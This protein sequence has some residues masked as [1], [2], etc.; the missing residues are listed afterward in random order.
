MPSPLRFALASARRA[1]G[2]LNFP[3]VALIIL[4]VFLSAA[5]SPAQRPPD[6]CSFT[7]SQAP[8]V[9]FEISVANGQSEFR[10]GEMIPLTAT[11]STGVQ[12][13]YA[14]EMAQTN[15]TGRDMGAEIVCVDPPATDP[16]SDHFLNSGMGGISG[17]TDLSAEPRSFPVTVNDWVSLRPGSYRVRVVGYRI[18]QPDPDNPQAPRNPLVMVSNEVSIDVAAA[19]KPWQARE[20]ASAE[21]ELDSA[22]PQSS[23]AIHAAQVM[24]FLET[25]DSTRELARRFEDLSWSGM[26]LRVGL[27]A[28]PYSNVAIQTMKAEMADPAHTITHAYIDTLIELELQSDPRFHVT[29]ILGETRDPRVI[30]AFQAKNTEMEKRRAVYLDQA[31]AALPSKMPVARAETA[32]DLL[33][34]GLR[35]DGDERT[36]AIEALISVWDSLP[37]DRRSS[38][39][40]GSW[41]AVA[42]PAWLP[43][44]RAIADSAPAPS[45]QPQPQ[46]R[47]T[48]IEYIYQLAPAEGR[49]RILR[50]IAQPHGD[51][52]IEVLGMLPD[53]QLPQFDRN[54]VD[55][56]KSDRL[57]YLEMQLVERY[58]SGAIFPDVRAFHEARG[59][60]G[61][62]DA[63]AALLRYFLR[64]NPDYG[65]AQVVSA[66]SAVGHGAM[67]F[68]LYSD[69]KED[70]AR[71]QIEP[72]VIA[73][74]SSPEPFVI[75]QAARA[76][77]EYGSPKAGAA[78]WARL[79]QLHQQ[80]DAPAQPVVIS[81]SESWP[82][83]DR[84]AEFSILSAL[85]SGHSWFASA[86]MI[87]KLKS[88]SDPYF[89]SY[90]EEEASSVE[91]GNFSLTL[92]WAHGAMQY[93][94]GSSDGYGITSLKEKLAQFPTGS[95]LFFAGAAAERTAH[96]DDIHAVEAAAQ[97]AGL[98]LHTQQQE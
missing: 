18:T 92:S 21:S 59:K 80:G 41:D 24:T 63:H 75:Q 22:G 66:A 7:A 6:P 74:L 25:E 19:G 8:E 94:V 13:K 31:L 95:A 50:E 48:A 29:P 17:S 23:E 78:L 5:S 68:W 26:Q 46:L 38:V 39:L 51:I 10:E 42:S 70:V 62:C 84:M 1:R 58:A 32:L 40:L 76:L 20:L 91:A 3:A 65:V 49:E 4:A 87:R 67:C 93:Q 52:G 88:I 73:R 55:G 30:A 47:Q 12:R 35:L 77:S 60:F 2:R 43:I 90:L 27:Y 96:A 61:G 54:F 15:S 71:P 14:I 72:L 53:R 57:A 81:T 37:A 69:L 44:L 89:E 16:L 98:T 9:S 64:V 82:R 11:Y 28:S 79:E 34:G 86:E 85:V 33:V 97:A 56:L 83:K 36:R 45:Q